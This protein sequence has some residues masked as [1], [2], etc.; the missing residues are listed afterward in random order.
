MK[1]RLIIGFLLVSLIVLSGCESDTPYNPPDKVDSVTTTETSSEAQTIQEAKQEPEKSTETKPKIMVF[2]VGE[3]ATDNELKVTVNKVRFVSKIDEKNNEFLVAKAEVGKEYAI[4]DIT[5]ENILLNETQ[6]V[7]T[8]GETT[9]SDEEGYNYDIDFEA[10]VALEKGFK[11]GEILPGM[12]K[13]GEIGYLVP[14]DATDLKFIYKFDL[15]TG[16]S[17][18]FDIK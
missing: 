10:L 9:I 15:F 7:S 3:T 12:K 8:F 11:D 18:V 6:I 5:V 14:S 17:A 13:R 1:K 4:L 2:N 16:T